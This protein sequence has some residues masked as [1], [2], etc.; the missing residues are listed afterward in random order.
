MLVPVAAMLSIME[1]I[2]FITPP[3]ARRRSPSPE[4]S[5]KSK[6]EKKKE[7]KKSKKRK[8]RESDSDEDSDASADDDDS[9]AR[10]AALTAL[11]DERQAREAAER[12]K[13]CRPWRVSFCLLNF[14][15]V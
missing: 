4:R 1:S 12:A 2:A 14:R 3:Q 6:K 15:A 7:H 13:V 11:R 9:R 8:H 5:K 10:G